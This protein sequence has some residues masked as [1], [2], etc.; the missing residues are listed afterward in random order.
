M[1]RYGIDICLLCSR[2]AGQTEHDTVADGYPVA[3]TRRLHKV[4]FHAEDYAVERVAGGVCVRQVFAEDEPLH[5]TGALSGLYTLC[6]EEA[7]EFDMAVCLTRVCKDP[8]HSRVGVYKALGYDR[9]YMDLSDQRLKCEHCDEPLCML[10]SVNNEITFKGS[11]YTTCF[12]CD[13]VMRKSDAVTLCATCSRRVRTEVQRSTQTCLRCKRFVSSPESDAR[14][15][16]QRGTQVFRFEKDAAAYLCREHRI[17]PPPRN[18]KSRAVL[19]ILADLYFSRPVAEEREDGVQR[20]DEQPAEDDGVVDLEARYGDLRVED[21]VA[22]P[23][24]A[25]GAPAGEHLPLVGEAAEP[26]AAL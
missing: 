17:Y 9:C 12:M 11:T 10:S 2:A 6:V 13:T 8:V 19:Q 7:E 3:W 24:P 4:R 20:E 14:S 22:V 25:G 1:T 26:A 23:G 21:G 16:T 15:G 5:E 18:V